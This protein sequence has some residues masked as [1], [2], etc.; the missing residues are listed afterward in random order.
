MLSY[1]TPVS[2]AELNHRRPDV[3]WRRQLTG[4]R[5]EGEI[6]R[7]LVRG[8]TLGCTA[9]SIRGAYPRCCIVKQIEG[10][11]RADGWRRP[12]PS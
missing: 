4:K 8:Y 11:G 9:A 3:K 10:E 12:H 2:S 6:L 7:N 1:L 5:K